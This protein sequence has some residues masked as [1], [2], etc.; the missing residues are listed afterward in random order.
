[1]SVCYVH[2]PSPLIIGIN[3][4]MEDECE[5]FLPSLLLAKGDCEDYSDAMMGLRTM[6]R[7]AVSRRPGRG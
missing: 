6:P 4:G 2:P 7:T 1:M 5:K 3:G